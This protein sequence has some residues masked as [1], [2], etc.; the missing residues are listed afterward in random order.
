[1]LIRPGRPF[2]SA[3]VAFC[4]NMTAL[5][6]VDQ[7]D[8]AAATAPISVNNWGAATLVSLFVAGAVYGKEKLTERNGA[9]PRRQV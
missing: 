9:E 8:L 1:M 3:F 7:I 6:A 5:F 2:W 4:S